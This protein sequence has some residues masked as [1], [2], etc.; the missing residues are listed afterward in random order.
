M[1]SSFYPFLQHSTAAA[2]AR[3]QVRFLASRNYTAVVLGT[4]PI[5]DD[6]NHFASRLCWCRVRQSF[7]VYTVSR[8]LS[9]CSLQY[10][11]TISRTIHQSLRGNHSVGQ[12]LIGAITCAIVLTYKNLTL[13]GCNRIDD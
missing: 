8:S 9:D 13:I 4:V 6:V 11:S 10:A 3:Y 2:A 12:Q 1:F 7:I 5:V